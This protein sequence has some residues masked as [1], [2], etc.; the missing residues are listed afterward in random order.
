MFA[1]NGTQFWEFHVGRIIVL[2]TGYYITRPGRV[3][4]CMD[5]LILLHLFNIVWM[6]PDLL[7]YSYISVI[8]GEGRRVKNKIDREWQI[9][10]YAMFW[11]L[12]NSTYNIDI[13]HPCMFCRQWNIYGIHMYHQGSLDSSCGSEKT[14][15]AFSTPIAVA[16]R[17]NLSAAKR[18]EGQWNIMKFWFWSFLLWM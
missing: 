4:A 13:C 5:R 8:W 11:T 6:H 12:R 1:Y 7:I 3:M 14:S 10:L 18:E 17:E 15:H 2:I 16:I 9:S